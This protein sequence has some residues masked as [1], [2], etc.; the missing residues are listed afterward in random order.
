MSDFIISGEV[1]VKDKASGNMIIDRPN[2]QSKQAFFDTL[3]K[4]APVMRLSIEEVVKYY[5]LSFDEVREYV[6]R[7]RTEEN[8][9]QQEKGRR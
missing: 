8:E 3:H 5:N 6:E 1:K 2:V 9:Q 4:Y 7:R